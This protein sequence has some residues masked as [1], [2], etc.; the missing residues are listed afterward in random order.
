MSASK[1]LLV[2]TIASLAFA[3]A[4]YARDAVFT[5][6][7]EAPV[8]EQTRVIAQNTIWNCAG[9]T[10]VARPN[11]ASTVRSCRQFVRHSGAR[12][13]AYGPAGNE[14]SADEIARCNGDASATVE[15]R[16]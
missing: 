10:C 9:D 14:L 16:N 4:A 5:A 11:H 1:S 3:G 6:K 8:A 2:A 7:L 13:V 15:A 12:V